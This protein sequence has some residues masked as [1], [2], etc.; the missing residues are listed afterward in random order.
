MLCGRIMGAGIMEDVKRFVI[1][2]HTR[3]NEPVHW[4]LMLQVGAVLET[5]RLDVPPESISV[6]PIEAVKIFDHPLRF[7]SYEGAVN[8]GK[9]AVEIADLGTYKVLAGS[10]G[11]N[12]IEFQGEFLRGRFKLVRVEGENW[13]IKAEPA[14]E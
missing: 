2:R 7:L 4:D 13:Q 11:H 9:G 5:Y 14:Q 1:Q 10:E 12:E 6:Q 3:Q 8:D